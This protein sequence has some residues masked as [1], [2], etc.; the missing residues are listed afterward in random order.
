[1]FG[2]RGKESAFFKREK[3]SWIARDKKWFERVAEGRV[4]QLVWAGTLELL[5]YGY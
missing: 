3:N 5:L 2:E 1:L 4:G